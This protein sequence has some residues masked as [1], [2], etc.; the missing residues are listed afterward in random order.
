MKCFEIVKAR[1]QEQYAGWTRSWACARTQAVVFFERPNQTKP[2]FF[3]KTK[4]KPNRSFLKTK[5]QTNPESKMN[6]F[7]TG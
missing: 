3:E 6:C 1:P 2:V 4:T 7:D 5:N